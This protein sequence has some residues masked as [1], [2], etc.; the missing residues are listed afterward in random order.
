MDIYQQYLN[1]ML[2][3]TEI[4]GKEKES[5]LNAAE[6]ICEFLDIPDLDEVKLNLGNSLRLIK[7]YELNYGLVRA[8]QVII[9]FCLI[10]YLK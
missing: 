8:Q 2:T 3:H 10:I 6:R 1:K 4:L 7:S 5:S 9:N